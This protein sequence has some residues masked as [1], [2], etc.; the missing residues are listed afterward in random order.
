MSMDEICLDAPLVSCDGRGRDDGGV[1]AK[2]DDIS[3]KLFVDIVVGCMI[4]DGIS[5]ARVYGIFV[6]DLINVIYY[7]T[8]AERTY[9]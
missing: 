3:A 2:S 8:V 6:F 5:T 9:S 7:Q 1:T 4:G